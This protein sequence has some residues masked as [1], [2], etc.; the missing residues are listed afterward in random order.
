MR[1]EPVEHPDFLDFKA[2]IV[3]CVLAVVLSVQG[4]QGADFEFLTITYEAWPRE[5]WRLLTSCLLHAGWIHLLFNVIWT[6]RFGAILEPVLGLVPMIGVIVLLGASSSAAQWAIGAG[7][8]GLSGIGYGLFGVLW[9]LDRYHPR[10]RGVM[11]PNTTALFVIWFFVCIVATELGTMRIANTAHGVGAG[12]GG[13]IGL[14]LTPAGRKRTLGWAGLALVTLLIALASTVG[15]PYVNYS[16]QRVMEL[17]N[18]AIDL[19]DDDPARAA[20][21]LERAIELDDADFRPWHNLGIA[22]RHLG[23]LAESERAFARADELEA[24]QAEAGGG[25]GLLEGL[26]LGD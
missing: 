20:E 10:F 22:Y 13:L 8:V 9:A 11:D 1:S 25:G 4:F 3:L 7:G 18:H 26:D 21:M 19:I 24:R 6:W 17:N 2:S 5:P 15:R 12:V 14:A 16:E 23:R